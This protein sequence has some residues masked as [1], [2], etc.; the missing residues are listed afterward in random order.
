MKTQVRRKPPSS[1]E[2]EEILTNF[3]RRP[4][5]VTGKVDIRPIKAL[6]FKKFSKGHVLR[7]V[8]LG[9]RDLLSGTE[10]LAKMETW[11]KL[12]QVV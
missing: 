5:Q 7:N 3:Q 4:Y 6:V 2:K 11:L 10:F 12:L 8:V 1:E 9:E